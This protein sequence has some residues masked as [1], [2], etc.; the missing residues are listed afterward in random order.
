MPDL[1]TEVARFKEWASAYPV[2]ER[3]GEWEEDYDSDGWWSLQNAV[4]EFVAGHG[5]DTWSAEETDAILYAIARNNEVEF[6]SNEIRERFEPAFMTLARAALTRGEWEAR[7]QI[8]NQLGDLDGAAGGEPEQLLLHYVEDEIEYVRRR[9]LGALA[10]IGSPEVERLALKAWHRPDEYQE[11]SRMMA[12]SCLQHIR[13]SKLD[14]LLCEAETDGRQ[15]L[16]AS[17]RRIRQGEII[18]P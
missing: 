2:S 9:A 7:W 13:S 15:Y 17:A 11:Y 16:S 12:L 10:R 4:L 6:L 8:A 18:P 5:P 14:S 1:L 3:S